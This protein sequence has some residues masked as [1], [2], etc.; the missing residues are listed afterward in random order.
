MKLSTDGSLIVPCHQ[1]VSLQCRISTFQEGLSINHLAWVGQDGKCLCDVNATGVMG[2]HPGNTPSAMECSYNPQTQLTLTLLQVQPLER[3][4]YLC[5]LRSNHGVKEAT[6][7]VELQG[8]CPFIL[9]IYLFI[10]F[11]LNFYPFFSPISR[12]PIVVVATILSHCY[13]LGRDEG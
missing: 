5:K 3:G 10:Y 9:F 6:T 12:Y 1:S 13:G 11:Y 2:T 8:E 7:T 4:K